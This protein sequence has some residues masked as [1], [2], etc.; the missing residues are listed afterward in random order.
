[1]MNFYSIYSSS[2]STKNVICEH[3]GCQGLSQL[4]Q[5]SNPS[6]FSYL[7]FNSNNNYDY[8]FDFDVTLASG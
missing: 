7:Q 6:K 2:D 4:F 1:M 8:K 5:V 3:Y